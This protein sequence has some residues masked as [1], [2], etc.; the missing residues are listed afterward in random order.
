MKKAAAAGLPVS[1]GL[2][3]RKDGDAPPAA[4]PAGPALP[5]VADAPPPPPAPPAPPDAEAPPADPPAIAIVLQRTATPP[6]DGAPLPSRRGTTLRR[7]RTQHRSRQRSGSRSRSRS[8]SVPRTAPDPQAAA[9]CDAAI[10]TALAYSRTISRPAGDKPRGELEDFAD[11]V[12]LAAAAAAASAAVEK[13]VGPARA[14]TLRRTIART[15]RRRLAGGA[16]PAIPA[17][18][19]FPDADPVPE[20]VP[21]PDLLSPVSAVGGGGE[22]SDGDEFWEAD[23]GE[24]VSDSSYPPSDRSS[25]ASSGSFHSNRSWET[26]AHHGRA[27]IKRRGARRSRAQPDPDASPERSP[28]P[29]SDDAEPDLSRTFFRAL[30]SRTGEALSLLGSSA[31]LAAAPAALLAGPAAA[32]LLSAGGG[33]ASRAGGAVLGRYARKGTVARVGR[34]KEAMRKLNAA[35]LLANASEGL[36]QGKGRLIGTA[37]ASLVENGIVGGSISLAAGGLAAAVAADPGRAREVLSDPA[38]RAAAEYLAYLANVSP[39]L[40]PPSLRGV[41]EAVGAIAGGL[42]VADEVLGGAEGAPDG[43]E[44]GDLE[45]EDGD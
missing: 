22:E 13:E 45:S 12:V 14:R 27:T 1:L 18:D 30:L 11:A 38:Y 7:T 40:L 20:T 36:L 43:A 26:P 41:A 35:E 28:S 8:R 39:W 6:S 10:A 16:A 24:E 25:I 15:T 4:A 21:E 33:L 34:A 9:E 3:R 32:G 44:A 17:P 5:P 2:R 42:G 29:S 19:P 31:S 37:A 23:E